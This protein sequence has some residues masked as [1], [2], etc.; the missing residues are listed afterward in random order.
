MVTGSLYERY[1]D[2]LRRGH[3][4]TLRGR[5]DEAIGAYEEAAALAPDRSLP[6]ASLGGVFARQG[7][8]ADA[9]A[10]FRR[11]LELS[12][13]DEAALAGLADVLVRAA[14]PLGASEALVRLAERRL[15]AGHPADAADVARQASTLLE[16]RP[17]RGFVDRLVDRRGDATTEATAAEL[18][19]R[20]QR[21]L[22][23]ADAVGPSSA[24][25]EAAPETDDAGATAI[26]EIARPPD[27]EQLLD[28]ADAA[29]RA[30]EAVVAL[31]RYRQAAAAFRSAGRLDAA[32]D[33]GLPALALAPADPALHLILADVYLDRGWRD[34]AADKLALLERLAELDGDEATAT[35]AR[36]ITEDRIGPGDDASS[37]RGT[38]AGGPS[39]G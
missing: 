23:T 10:A 30:G 28:E 24:S 1:K 21:L 36:R 14:D 31:E 25:P 5:P 7:R 11:A 33:A 34:G 37:G 15:A 12:P 8:G 38:S 3:V 18:R 9:V 4:A 19:E 27:P 35:A 29:D 39:A 6:Y 22:S 2:A 17:K 26:S 13:G 32:L 16:A 20:V